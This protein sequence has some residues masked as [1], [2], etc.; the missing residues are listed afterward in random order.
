MDA[1]PRIL[2]IDDEPVVCRSC[3][4]ILSEEGYEVSTVSTG[5]EGLEKVRQ[6]HFDVII[7]DVKIP[8]I[9]GIEVLEC[10]RREQP[11]MPVVMITGYASV[12]TGVQAMKLGAFDY[13]PKPFTPEEMS[14][15]I[16]K[17]LESRKEA[18]SEGEVP[19]TIVIRKDA[20]ME[21]LNRT[22]EDS[23]SIDELS[24]KRQYRVQIEV[25]V[26]AEDESEAQEV[27]EKMIANRIKG[28]ATVVHVAELEDDVD[29]GAY[30]V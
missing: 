9:G 21:A 30:W 28:P 13:L 8:D 29:R 16:G 2:V 23:G 25:V 22:A 26:G 6:E 10:I 19:E 3:R 17:A 12:D 18:P 4:K 1:N 7:A 20:V 11:D 15:I 24:E 27:A 5:R 14:T